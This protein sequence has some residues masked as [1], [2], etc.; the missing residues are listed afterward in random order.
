MAGQRVNKEENMAQRSI[1][2]SR[3]AVAVLAVSVVSGFLQASA[4]TEQR[5]SVTIKDFKFVTTQVPLRLGVPTVITIVNNDVERHDFGSSMFE[6]VPTQVESAGIIS[7]GRGI[8]GVLID[9]K[10]T[11]E[12][13]FTMD[14]PGRHEFRCSIH[15]QMKGEILLLSVEAV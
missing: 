5:V 14:K 15:P 8:A 6:G 13:R 7:Y 12:I 3:I 4:Q 10:R 2:F 11:T 9:P 1:R